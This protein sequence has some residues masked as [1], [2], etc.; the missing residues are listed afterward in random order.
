MKKTAFFITSIF[1]SLLCVKSWAQ[2]LPAP[3]AMLQNTSD[4]LIAALKHNKASLKKNPNV[5]YQIV[6][7][8]LVPHVDLIGMS[9]S[10]LGRQAWTNATPDQ[11]QR[12]MQEFKNLLI[13][14]YSSALQNY[15]NQ[16]VRFLPIR[17][18]FN[19]QTRV[20]VNSEILQQNG[21]PISV[22]YRLIKQNNDWK[23]Y[24]FSVDGVSMLE[25]FRSQF[26]TDLNHGDLNY[27]IDKL[28]RHNR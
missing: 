9:R 28:A 21:P 12:F 3:V 23:V 7:K 14:T 15:N 5:V 2:T 10:V 25:S 16:T 11:K 13:H 4:Q 24:D 6:D 1:L 20:Q 26:A 22:S 27:L 8:I 17:G 18:G 19:D